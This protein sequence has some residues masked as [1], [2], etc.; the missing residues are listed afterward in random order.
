[1][2]TRT[3]LVNVWSERGRQR[4]GET[5]ERGGRGKRERGERQR[6]ERGGIEGIERNRGVGGGRK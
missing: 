3:C 2:E 1:M 6:E 5:G 4:E